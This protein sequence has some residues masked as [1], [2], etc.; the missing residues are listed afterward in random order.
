MAFRRQ[1]RKWWGLDW[2]TYLQMALKFHADQ[3]VL[4][5]KKQTRNILTNWSGRSNVQWS[6]FFAPYNDTPELDI[7]LKLMV[8]LPWTQNVCQ[9]CSSS[10]TPCWPVLISVACPSVLWLDTVV[11]GL[12]ISLW[13]KTS[14]PASNTHCISAA[15]VLD[16]D[17]FLT[18][19]FWFGV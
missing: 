17:S 6:S 16:V 12:D 11:P 15:V 7:F 1:Q 5:T 8:R 2:G 14:L 13:S 3:S 10:S 18:F 4:E 19:F 9:V